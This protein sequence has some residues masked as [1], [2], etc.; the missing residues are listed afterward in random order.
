MASQIAQASEEED[1]QMF[2]FKLSNSV[3]RNTPRLATLVCGS[4]HAIQ[5]PHYLATTSRGVVP[6]LTPD[7]QLSHTSID[8]VYIS[9]EDCPVCDA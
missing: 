4:R 2:S 1:Q 5:T 7:V 9:L 6:H 3:A 8:G